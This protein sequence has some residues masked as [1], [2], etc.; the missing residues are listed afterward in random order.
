VA[1]VIQLQQFGS[2]CITNERT[3]D[4]IRQCRSIYI[5]RL[6]VWCISQQKNTPNTATMNTTAR[7]NMHSYCNNACDQYTVPVISEGVTG[8][9][10]NVNSL[11]FIQLR[12]AR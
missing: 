11:F 10:A 12:D 8:R 9:F 6:E 1:K 3:R 7:L 4:S 2:D 5:T